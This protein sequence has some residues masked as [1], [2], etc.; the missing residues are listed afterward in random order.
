MLRREAGRLVRFEEELGR[1]TGKDGSVRAEDVRR[2]LGREKGLEVQKREVEGFVRETLIARCYLAFS[3]VVQDSQFAALGVVLMGVL[4]SV[5]KEIGLPRVEVEKITGVSLRQTGVDKGEVVGREYG[6]PK[7]RREDAEEVVE[8][9]MIVAKEKKKEDMMEN[10][11]RTVKFAKG[12]HD[13]GEDT[14]ASATVDMDTAA[15]FTSTAKRKYTRKKKG[16]KNAIDQ[17]FAS[18]I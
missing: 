16:K 5:G 12:K 3:T 1:S 2:Q 15:S 9:S 18:L 13:V 4:A 11:V 7:P 6:S 14:N 8:R 10:E 17:L